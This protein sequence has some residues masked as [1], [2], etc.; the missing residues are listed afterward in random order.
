MN[1]VSKIFKRKSS[2]KY[3]ALRKSNS[4]TELNKKVETNKTSNT[5][6]VYTTGILNWLNLDEE[7]KIYLKWIE[8]FKK[9]LDDLP[10]KYNVRVIHYDPNMLRDDNT[11]NF[12]LNNNIYEEITHYINDHGKNIPNNID[13]ERISIEFIKEPLNETVLADIKNPHI[14]YDFAEIFIQSREKLYLNLSAYSTNKNE[15]ILF[16]NINVIYPEYWLLNNYNIDLKH[17]KLFNLDDKGNV[18]T[19]ASKFNKLLYID[20]KDSETIIDFVLSKLKSIWIDHR[21]SYWEQNKYRLQLHNFGSIGEIEWQK[22]T[23][24]LLFNFIWIDDYKWY[25]IKEFLAS[26]YDDMLHEVL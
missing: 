26:Q 8:Y 14:I 25:M 18:E 12:E 7:Q 21:N 15:K 20:N 4:E 11:I 13:P 23:I 2:G 17:I 6:Y 3:S 16:D 1:F 24:E 5:F 22:I 9:I 19:Y 10:T